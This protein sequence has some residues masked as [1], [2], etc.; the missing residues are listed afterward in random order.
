[1]PVLSQ[2]CNNCCDCDVAVAHD[3]GAD[4]DTT[5]DVTGQ[6][7]AAHNLAITVIG[8]NCAK[9]MGPCG[10][11]TGP[12]KWRVQVYADGALIYDSGCISGNLSHTVSVPAGTT[13]LRFVTNTNCDSCCESGGGVMA[14]YDCPAA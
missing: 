4:G 12:E 11:G 8:A 7:Y 9:L 14:F 1:M 13:E 2:P 5:L 3:D 6:F 10:G